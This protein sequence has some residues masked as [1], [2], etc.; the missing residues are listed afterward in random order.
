MLTFSFLTVELYSLSY[1]TYHFISLSTLVN[2]F[3]PA[4]I[5][6]FSVHNQMLL[7]TFLTYT[8]S[9]HIPQIKLV[10]LNTKNQFFQT[11]KLQII[12]VFIKQF[13]STFLLFPSY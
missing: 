8:F 11:V 12:K 4:V 1:F 6:M 9:P 13:F 2:I 7:I 5:P 10:L 3:T